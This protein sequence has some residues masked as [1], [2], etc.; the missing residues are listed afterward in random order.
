MRKILGTIMLFVLSLILIACETESVSI[1]III[2]NEEDTFLNELISEFIKLKNPKYKYE[3]A[4]SLSSQ[5]KQNQQVIEFLKKDVDLL[6]IN[7]VDRLAARTIIEKTGKD[8]IPIIFFNREPQHDDL[9][10]RDNLY[11]VGADP[12]SQGVLQ[13]E[14]AA[15]LF[16]DKKDLNKKYDRNEDNVIQ[17]VIIKGEAG[18]QDTEDRTTES[19]QKLKQ[20]GYEVE[21]LATRVANWNRDE[22]YEKMEELYLEYGDE[23]ELVLSNNDDM[24]LGAID[25]YLNNNIEVDDVVFIGVDKIK[26]AVTYIE[27][28]YLNGTVINDLIK[29][30]KAINQ[31]TEIIINDLDINKLEFELTK[32]KY[33]LIPGEIYMK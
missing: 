33:I 31:L 12:K 24:A 17:T 22:S 25:Y 8:D 21:V 4:Y 9:R 18:H 6:V 29:Q 19:I 16:G 15:E 11:Y 2:Y 14:I 30:A 32:D 10:I 23:T 1:G 7:P 13:G 26:E 3:I 20:L 27:K 5:S 28:G